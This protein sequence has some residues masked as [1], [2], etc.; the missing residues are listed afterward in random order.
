MIEID[1]PTIAMHFILNDSPF[2]GQDGKF[3]TS[4]HLEERLKRETLADVALQVSPLGENDIAV[5]DGYATK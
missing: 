1:P 5:Y 3:V 2:V 4:R